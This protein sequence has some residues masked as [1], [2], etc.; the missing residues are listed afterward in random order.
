MTR[1]IVLS[2]CD[3]TGKMVEPWA[4]RG[5]ECWC[6]DLQHEPGYNRAGNIIYVGADLRKWQLPVGNGVRYCIGF[7]FPPCTHLA[8]SGARWFKGKGLRA[9]SE[10]IELVARCAEILD[11][12]GCPWMIENPIGSLGTYWRQPDSRFDP[13]DYAGYLADPDPDAYT[14]RTCLWVGNGF[15][16][17]LPRPVFPVHG[18]KMHLLPPSDDRANLRSE[19]PGG[20]A[21]AVFEANVAKVNRGIFGAA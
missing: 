12:A 4:A 21:Q 19:T 16:V 17:P 6:I 5:F 3:R 2:L 15:N 13:C 7:G 8:A 11:E 18:S 14:K 10:A 9:L 20:F 1:N